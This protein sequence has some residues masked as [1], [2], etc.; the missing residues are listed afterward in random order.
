[1]SRKRRDR[2]RRWL[3]KQLER[4]INSEI[5]AHGFEAVVRI[6]GKRIRRPRVIRRL[7]SLIPSK[8][9]VSLD[10]ARWISF[11]R[12]VNARLATCGGGLPIGDGW[13]EC[14]ECGQERMTTADPDEWQRRRDNRW[15]VTG[16]W[17][18]AVDC[19]NH[20]LAFDW[21]GRA[22]RWGP[23][24]TAKPTAEKPTEDKAQLALAMS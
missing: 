17:P 18:G 21:E 12:F 3:G 5:A 16:Y 19:C 23:L 14:P 10:H 8:F 15:K 20:I 13:I 2:A 24:E 6:H 7:I 4:A 1:M 22:R 11:A 9:E